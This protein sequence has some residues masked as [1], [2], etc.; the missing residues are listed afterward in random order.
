MNEDEP[1]GGAPDG[2]STHTERAYR[3]RYHGLLVRSPLKNMRDRFFRFLDY[4]SANAPAQRVLIHCLSAYLCLQMILLSVLVLSGDL[5]PHDATAA[6][7]IVNILSLVAVLAPSSASDDTFVMVALACECVTFVLI[8]AVMIA[9]GYFMR[10]SK[11]PHV[12]VLVVS[13]G[14]NGFIDV[15]PNLVIAIVGG[16]LSVAVSPHDALAIV[17]TIVGVVLSAPIPTIMRHYV[18]STPALRPQVI[19]TTTGLFTECDAWIQFISTALVGFGSRYGGAI[20]VVC[21]YASA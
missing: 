7:Y 11:L 4:V 12:I 8:V 17:V 9:I 18:S 15:W 1:Q 19:H 21:V 2:L 14:L 16:T 20:G 3:R 5:W 13:C 10:Y 6:G